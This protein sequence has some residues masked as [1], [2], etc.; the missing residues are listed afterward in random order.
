MRGDESREEKR[1]EE[2][3]GGERG[4]MGKR[5]GVTNKTRTA[6]LTNAW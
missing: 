4:R 5:K 3:R 2:R 6:D 1:R